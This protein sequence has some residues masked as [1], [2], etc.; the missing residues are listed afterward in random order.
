MKGLK[1][2]PWTLPVILI[3][4]SIFPLKGYQVTDELRDLNSKLRIIM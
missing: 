1:P 3:L 4:A 2:T